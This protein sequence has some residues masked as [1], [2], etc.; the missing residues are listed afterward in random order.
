[1]SKRAEEGGQKERGAWRASWIVILA[2][3][4]ILSALLYF[5]DAYRHATSSTPATGAPAASPPAK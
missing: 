4:A 1:M 5:H 2:M 3:V